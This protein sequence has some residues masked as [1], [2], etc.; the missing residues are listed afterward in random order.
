MRL[1]GCKGATLLLPRLLYSLQHLKTLDIAYCDFGS[2]ATQLLGLTACTQLSE[3][4]IA[5]CC[6]GEWYGFWYKGS[7]LP[8]LSALQES[9]SS[10]CLE[11]FLTIERFPSLA[12][13]TRL[14]SLEVVFCGR[15][16]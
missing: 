8:P 6:R 3:L 15:L 1:H 10:L 13:L 4:R 9:L 5:S 2:S 12:G 7:H 16:Q 14:T 11:R